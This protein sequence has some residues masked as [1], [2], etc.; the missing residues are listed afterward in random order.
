MT[1]RQ[2]DALINFFFQGK[3]E[4]TEKTTHTIDSSIRIAG[5]ESLLLW[6]KNS[7]ILV[8]FSNNQNMSHV[9][10]TKSMMQA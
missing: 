6:N 5:L 10:D 8:N 1:Y 7:L 4:N 3:Q 9:P 2:H